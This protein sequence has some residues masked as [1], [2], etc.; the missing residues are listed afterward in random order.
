M[1]LYK[2]LYKLNSDGHSIQSWQIHHNDCSY[3][4]ISG[5]HGMKQ[6]V[7]SPTMVE[8]KQK[9]SLLEQ[10]ISE[11]DS[12]I[13]KKRR[14]KYVP[15][16]KDVHGADDNLDGIS[17]MLA[18]KYN[19]HKDKIKFP[20]AAQ[21]KLD[22]I[23]DVTKKD[24]GGGTTTD[25]RMYSRGRKEFTS[26]THIKAELQDFYKSDETAILDGE[27][28]THV[29]KNDFQAIC[30][31]VKKTALHATPADIALQ[32]KVQYHIYDA[33]RIAGL[34][35][36]DPFRKRQE[37]IAKAFKGYK[38]IV[39]VETVYDIQNEAELLALKERWISEGNEGIMVRNQ[40]APYE[41]KRSYNL[42][43]WKDFIDEEFLIVGV[44]EGSGGLAGHAGSFTFA[45]YDNE[46]DR[47]IAGLDTSIQTF[48]AKM[49]G[50]FE[51]L[52]YLFEHQDECIGKK[53]TVRFQNRTN[54]NVPRFPV[55]RGIRDYE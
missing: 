41:G 5:K 14:K 11:C 26:C 20:C 30:K 51:N 3:W 33:P 39:V 2:Q 40:D 52:K 31:A 34:T 48:N 17:V 54:D 9:R 45:L 50:S 13:E 24:S 12:Q 15:E 29:Y 25:V 53:A 27:L 46:A 21:P 47:F 36:S 4:T 38:N 8:P 44:N 37:A 16:L 49:I 6:I 32:R 55:C 18:Q 35:E 19:E 23:R 43:K 1:T 7:S 42:Q 28:Y 10:V 22:G